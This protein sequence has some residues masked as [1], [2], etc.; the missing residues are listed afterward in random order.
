MA[1]HYIPKKFEGYTR[2]GLSDPATT[3]KIL[4]YWYAIAYPRVPDTFRLIGD[5]DE[6]VIEGDVHVK[7]HLRL[8]HIVWFGIKMLLDKRFRKL[9]K[10]GK[11]LAKELKGSGAEDQDEEDETDD[12]EKKKGKKAKKN[13]KARDDKDNKND[14]QT[15]KEEE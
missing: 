1:K 11:K 9:L 12:K 15:T 5:F 8:C 6:E 14:N 7:G 2:V 4:M 10:R 13:K 3:G